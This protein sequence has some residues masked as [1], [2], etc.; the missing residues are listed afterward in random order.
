MK[1]PK[2]PNR[3]SK[4]KVSPV[5]IRRWMVASTFMCGLLATSFGCRTSGLPVQ[6]QDYDPPFCRLQKP[7]ATK[8]RN[9]SLRVQTCEERLAE[10]M[11]V[12]LQQWIRACFVL[13]GCF[14]DYTC[15]TRGSRDL[16]SNDVATIS[17]LLSALFCFLFFFCL[18]Y[19]RFKRSFREMRARMQNPTKHTIAPNSLHPCSQET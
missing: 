9:P 3:H 14:M 4:G 7:R 8:H 16:F 12:G 2:F 11:V 6:C 5:I 19:L 18:P 17:H 1:P 10:K 13:A 15:N